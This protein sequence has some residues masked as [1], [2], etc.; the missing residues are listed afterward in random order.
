MEINGYLTI[1]RKQKMLKRYLL[2]LML[3]FPI[4]ANAYLLVEDL[5]N[6][7]QNIVTAIQNGIQTASGAVREVSAKVREVYQLAIKT[8]AVQT[9]INTYKNFLEAAKIYHKTV[10]LIDIVTGNPGFASLLRV[11][12]DRDVRNVL[13]RDWSDSV[14]LI[15]DGSDS[16]TGTDRRLTRAMRAFETGNARYLPEDIFVE[17]GFFNEKERYEERY[18]RNKTYAV[19]AEANLDRAKENVHKIEMMESRSD[20]T[21]T[22]QER[23]NLANAI[24]IQKYQAQLETN[25]E[26]FKLNK[27]LNEKALEETQRRANDYKIASASF[28]EW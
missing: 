2:I 3:S 15:K 18:N 4:Q 5:L 27:M 12:G 11:A 10:R 24:S 23:Q 19:L 14:D 16:F 6:L 25:N 13:G 8:Q 17:P 20:G 9:T 1:W 7:P 22:T 26:L 28:E 21:D